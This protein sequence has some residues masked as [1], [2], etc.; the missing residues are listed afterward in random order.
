LVEPAFE[1]G[2]CDEDAAA[3]ADDAEFGDDVFVEVVAADAEEA[4]GFVGAECEPRA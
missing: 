3:T 2:E 1:F 4:G